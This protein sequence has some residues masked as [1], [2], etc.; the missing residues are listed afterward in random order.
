[1]KT[2]QK[3]ACT[4]A[5]A[6]AVSAGTALAYEGPVPKGVPRLEHVFVIMMEN[7]GYSQII[8]NPAEPYFNSLISSGTVSVAN[9]YFAIGHPSSTNYLEIVGGSNFGVRSDNSPDFHNANCVPNLQSGVINADNSAGIASPVSLTDSEGV[10]HSY[11]FA[12]TNVCPISGTGV[13]AI[14]D[15]VDSWNEVSPPANYLANFD[16]IAALDQAANID[17]KT[18]ADQIAEQ[19][20]HWKS[21]QESLPF[22][23]ADL[24]SYS[25]GTVNDTTPSTAPANANLPNVGNLPSTLYDQT[26]KAVSIPGGYLKLYAA[27]HNPFVYFK[28]VQENTLPNLGLNDVRPFDGAGGLYADLAVGFTVPEFSFIVPNQCNDQHG[29]GNGDAFCGFDP[30]DTGAQSGLNT[31]LIAQGDA[32]IQRL[33][34]SIKASPAWKFGRNAIVIVWDENDYSGVANAPPAGT[35]FPAPNQNHVVVTVD[36]N[37]RESPKVASSNYYNHFSLLKTIEGGLGL[38]CL[39]HACDKNVQVM[40]DLFSE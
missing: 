5:I 7:H 38:P 2:R 25:N 40:S 1:M 34:T 19:G 27:K 13:D 8:G 20:R 33:V 26:Q 17:G 22:S 36:T 16:G 9:N 32:T 4:A 6:V 18:I 15:A 23:G 14:T 31:G 11:A 24:V 30:S 12:S 21:Y 28:S 35:A 39:N 3:I 10:S 37:Y 29:R